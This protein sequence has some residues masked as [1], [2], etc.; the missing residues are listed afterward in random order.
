MLDDT[1]KKQVLKD[2]YNRPVDSEI[3]IG[4]YF[5]AFAY[6][7]KINAISGARQS[8][9]E[10]VSAMG[11]SARAEEAKTNRMLRGLFSS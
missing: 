8:R 4:D 10:Y 5:M 3:T 7:Y 1:Q 11:A 6:L 2:A 9:L